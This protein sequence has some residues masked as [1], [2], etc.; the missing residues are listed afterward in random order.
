M[1]NRQTN[2]AHRQA[3]VLDGCDLNSSPEAVPQKLDNRTDQ[4]RRLK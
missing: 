1:T 4:I 3:A 2:K